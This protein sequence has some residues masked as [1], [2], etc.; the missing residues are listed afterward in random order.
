MGPGPWAL[1]PWAL[2]PWALGPGPGP[3]PRGRLFSPKT[4]PE[5]FGANYGFWRSTNH[6]KLYFLEIRSEL[7]VLEVNKSP[8]IKLFIN[9]EARGHTPAVARGCQN[10]EIPGTRTKPPE[11]L[12]LKAVWGIIEDC[13]QSSCRMLMTRY[14]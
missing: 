14:S 5:K 7:L 11:P 2:G 6:Q 9:S 12:Q 10:E 4:S 8:E 1:G 3:D 13:S